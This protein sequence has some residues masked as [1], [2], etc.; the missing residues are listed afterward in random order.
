MG[1]GCIKDVRECNKVLDY[2]WSTSDEGLY[3]TSNFGEWDDC[4][5]TSISDASFANEETAIQH[6]I[7]MDTETGSFQQGH[8]IGL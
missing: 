7:G 2:A 6:P 1:N 5:V 4:V 3:F 8:V